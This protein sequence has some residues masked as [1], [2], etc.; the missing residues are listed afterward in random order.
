M[1]V[2]VA[3][4]DDIAEG[5]RKYVNAGGKRIYV[6][7]VEGRFFAADAACPC[8]HYGGPLNRIVDGRGEPCVQCTVA[9]YTL[10]FSLRT[11]RNIDD[12]NFSIG[13]YPARLDDG[14]LIVSLEG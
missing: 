2:R 13:V 12:Y 1:D 9:C 14:D 8:P 3:K 10:T 6:F 4:A 5:Q 11:G 7:N